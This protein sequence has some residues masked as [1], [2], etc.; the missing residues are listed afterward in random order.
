MHTLRLAALLPLALGLL[1]GCQSTAPP[2]KPPAG[3]NAAATPV[4][5]STQASAPAAAANSSRPLIAV[6]DDRTPSTLRLIALDGREV[7]HTAIPSSASFSGVGGGMATFVA[8]G[9]LKGLRP[10]G[11]VVTLGSLQGFDGTS[12]TVSPDGQQ[13]LWATTSI[14]G[15][16]VTSKLMLGSK[17]D[18]G[19][20][21]ADLTAGTEPRVLRPYRWEAAGPVYQ[22]SATG[23]GGYSLF[24]GTTGPSWR[25]DP[26]NG[27]STSILDGTT[28]T[29]ADLS[30]DGTIAC[31]RHGDTAALEVLSP[32]GH[33]VEMPLARPAFNQHGALSFKPGSEATTLVLGG[34]TAVGADG[35]KE[36]YQTYLVDARMRTLKPFGPAGLR[37]GDGSWAW[38]SDGSLIAYRPAGAAG[39][40]SGTY[41]LS[42]GGSAKKIFASGTPVGVIHS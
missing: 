32:G 37:P 39:G 7:A 4:P 35:A 36:Q 20:T 5:A 10:G 23:L 8:D 9:Q 22:S 34:A 6:V 31:F 16:Q 19:R 33:V 24:N 21:V 2:A 25:L 28:C 29:I 26:Q 38:L 17:S 40:D 13:W 11:S 1:V 27:H 14:N 42:A 15:S 3:A 30:S 18:P 41:L 12:V